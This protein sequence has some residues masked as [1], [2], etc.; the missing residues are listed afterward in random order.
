MTCWET[1]LVTKRRI[2]LALFCACGLLAQDGKT[3][4][5]E[6]CAG[7]H[8]AASGRTPPVSA[9]RAMTAPAILDALN[10]GV[11]KMQAAPLSAAER[12]TVAAYLGIAPEKPVGVAANACPASDSR[13]PLPGAWSAWGV[14][15]ANTRFQTAAAAGL[16]AAQVPELKLKWAFDLG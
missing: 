10:N 6:H 2:G 16:T 13:K 3:I 14:D 8:D 5:Q 4:Y 15:P 11:M 7:C 1:F 9:L 12:Q